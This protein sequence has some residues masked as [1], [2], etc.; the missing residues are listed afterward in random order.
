MQFS[1]NVSG[2][3]YIIFFSI[4]TKA[5]DNNNNI[6]SKNRNNNKEIYE[7]ILDDLCQKNKESL[8]NPIIETN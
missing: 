8:S 2:I 4:I 1:D 3:L 5:T 7:S 6:P